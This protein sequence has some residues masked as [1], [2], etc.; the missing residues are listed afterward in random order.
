MK[1]TTQ[2]S[3]S[4]SSS[5]GRAASVQVGSAA[6]EELHVHVLCI[7]YLLHVDILWFKACMNH[8]Y[9]PQPFLAICFKLQNSPQGVYM[10]ATGQLRGQAQTSSPLHRCSCNC[11]LSLL[12]TWKP[13]IVCNKS[14]ENETSR[15]VAAE[16]ESPKHLG[17]SDCLQKPC[18][19]E[20]PQ[21]VAPRSRR[22]CR[23]VVPVTTLRTRSQ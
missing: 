12:E 11:P 1:P 19:K 5:R 10:L 13:Q 8:Q 18:S 20:T 21:A 3:S 2:W 7:L 14:S 16:D 23:P 9:S 15:Y 22:R 6:Q 4:R 17:T